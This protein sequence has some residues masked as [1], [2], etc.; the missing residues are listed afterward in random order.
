MGNLMGGL[1]YKE[2][3]TV[4][5]CDSTW[6]TDSESEDQPPGVEED[7]GT[8]DSLNPG[9]ATRCSVRTESFQQVLLI[10]SIHMDLLWRS[11]ERSELQREGKW[12]ARASAAII[13]TLIWWPDSSRLI[14][15]VKSRE[16]CALVLFHIVVLSKA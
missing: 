16:Q 9:E 13:R 7:S 12:V 14:F 5:E 10:T 1:R 4:E 15:S 8:S 3:G 11:R 6:E 2:P